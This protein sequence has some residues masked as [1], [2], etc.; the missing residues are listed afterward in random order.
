MRDTAW[1]RKKTGGGGERAHTWYERRVLREMEYQFPLTRGSKF[2]SC[3]T[4]SKKLFLFE[5]FA[6]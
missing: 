6:Q 1:E 5:R 2:A 3:A 4:C